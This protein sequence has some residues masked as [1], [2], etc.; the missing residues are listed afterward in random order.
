MYISDEQEWNKTKNTP[1]T[2]YNYAEYHV[3]HHPLTRRAHL[4]EKTGAPCIMHT[5]KDIR[6]HMSACQIRI[7]MRGGLVGPADHLG[8]PNVAGLPSR[9]ISRSRPQVS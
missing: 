3:W 9:C 4:A 6:A 7:R 1:K 8:R 5:R 2:P